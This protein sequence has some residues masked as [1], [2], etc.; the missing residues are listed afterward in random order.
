MTSLTA[1]VTSHS[2]PEG[3]RSIL[4]VLKYQT[5]HP[6]EVIVLC[7]D[8]PDVSRF[9]EHFPD[10][11]FH[12]EPNLEDWGHEKRAKGLQLA[13]GEYVG[14]FNDDDEYTLD[15]V[16]RMLGHADEEHADV[17]YCDWNVGHDCHFALGSSTSGNFIVRA[18]MAKGVG[19]RHRHYEADGMFIEDVARAGAVIS[20]L[21]VPLY[22][23]H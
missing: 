8:T 19:W 6:D 11:T 18:A 10:V 3:L 21:R 14:F 12:V 1:V 20:K 9:R 23:H 22:T 5:R 15:Y 2:N 13:G 4:G 17:V 16:E 7:S